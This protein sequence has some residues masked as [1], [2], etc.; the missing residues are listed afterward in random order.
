MEIIETFGDFFMLIFIYCMLDSPITI[1]PSST[2]SQYSP[3]RYLEEM[4]LAG[5]SIL[6]YRKK[7][8]DSLK[9][10]KRLEVNFTLL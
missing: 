6:K 1:I 9:F 4:S 8:G 3:A 7:K 10:Y 2:V 5:N